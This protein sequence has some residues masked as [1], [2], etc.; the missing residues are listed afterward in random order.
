[1]EFDRESP[2]FRL[3]HAH[4][5]LPTNPFFTMPRTS[6]LTPDPL[7]I[8]AAPPPNETQEQQAKRLERENEARRVSNEIDEKLRA[9]GAALKKNRTVKLLLLGQSE[10]GKTTT[11]KSMLSDLSLSNFAFANDVQRFSTNSCA[12]SVGTVRVQTAPR[13]WA[14]FTDNCDI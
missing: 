6:S 5:R 1:V 3:R 7:T 11:L 10:S 8:A 13:H 14:D 9:E 4:L 12:K 2:Y